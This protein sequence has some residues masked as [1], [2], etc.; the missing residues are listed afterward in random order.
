MNNGSKGFTLVEILL[1]SLL[2][3]IVALVG[4]STLTSIYRVDKNL[5]YLRPQQ[6]NL[7]YV[8]DYIRREVQCANPSD[9]TNL[10][11]LVNA[12]GNQVTI[13]DDQGVTK[14]IKRDPVPGFSRSKL[15]VTDSTTGLAKDLT[16]DDIDI[17]NFSVRGTSSN[18]ASPYLYFSVTA[19]RFPDGPRNQ[20]IT[21]SSIAMP[22][23]DLK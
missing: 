13:T 7:R 9:P 11:I 6:Q 20:T 17:T 1:A 3:A 5:S 8:M 18:I 21:V 19:E 22:R 16:S 12:S 4:T 2:F 10:T 23:E 15:T 14:T